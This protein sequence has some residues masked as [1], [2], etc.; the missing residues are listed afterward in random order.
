MKKTKA[1]LAIIAST[2]PLA[3]TVF[4]IGRH[5]A[6]IIPFLITSVFPLH[7]LTGGKRTYATPASET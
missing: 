6:E 7:F 2:A 4:L 1:Y 3:V 5:D